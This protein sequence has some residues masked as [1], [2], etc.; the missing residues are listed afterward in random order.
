MTISLLKFT[1]TLAFIQAVIATLG[2]LY[3]SEILLFTP[4]T[5][6]WYQ[7]IAMY[8]LVLILGVGLLDKDERVYRYVLPLSLTGWVISFYHILIQYSVI[9]ESTNV[10]TIIGSCTQRYIDWYGFITIPLMSF[11]AFTVINILMIFYIV[12]RNRGEGNK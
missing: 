4:C 5:L 11:I 3:F 7:R 12:G 6:C 8:P 10:C 9:E 2:S 1:V